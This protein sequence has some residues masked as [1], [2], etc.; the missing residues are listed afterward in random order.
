MMFRKR[1]ATLTIVLLC[2]RESARFTFT[3]T[4]E[5]RGEAQQVQQEGDRG[6]PI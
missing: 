2:S 5:L 1:V 4:T 6:P 3:Q